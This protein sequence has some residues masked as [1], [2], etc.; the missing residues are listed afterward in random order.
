[1]LDQVPPGAMAPK[2]LVFAAPK[3]AAKNQE[4]P[5]QI[6][7]DNQKPT[8]GL[9]SN[10]VTQVKTPKGTPQE[11]ADKQAVY[12]LYSSLKLRD[13]EK[14]KI[15]ARWQADKTCKWHN[16]Y[17][18][19]RSTTDQTADTTISGHGT[20]CPQKCCYFTVCVLETWFC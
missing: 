11:I 12:S 7:D 18:K 16:E 17:K 5:I 9:Q 8:P 13:P 20:K 15:L 2:K 4:P 19:S 10:F 14:A 1:M 3:K 6:P